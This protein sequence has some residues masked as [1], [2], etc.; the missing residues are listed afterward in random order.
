[1]DKAVDAL[2]SNH[3]MHTA[4]RRQCKGPA[5]SVVAAFERNWQQGALRT[6]GAAP[7]H[8]LWLAELHQLQTQ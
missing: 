4:S 8:M 6:G 3:H 7:E 5:G 2:S 1:M